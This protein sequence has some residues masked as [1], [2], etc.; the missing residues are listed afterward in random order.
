MLLSRRWHAPP[1]SGARIE[2]DRAIGEH[3]I[4]RRVMLRSVIDDERLFTPPAPAKRSR[5]MTALDGNIVVFLNGSTR[6]LVPGEFLVVRRIE[7]IQTRS[8]DLQSIEID[9]DAGT[10]VGDAIGSEVLEGRLPPS[11]RQA[12]AALAS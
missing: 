11:A 2:L 5:F 12:I 6:E 3:V 8:A 7:A 1:L 4:L 9:W 10:E